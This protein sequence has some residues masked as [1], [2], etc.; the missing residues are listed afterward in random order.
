MKFKLELGGGNYSPKSISQVKSMSDGV[1]SYGERKLER[2]KTS[3]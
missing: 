3:E 1:E 2:K